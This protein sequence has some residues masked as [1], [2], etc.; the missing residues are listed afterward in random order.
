MKGDLKTKIKVAI[1]LTIAGLA[2]ALL[3]MS[4]WITDLWSDLTPDQ[5]LF[6]VFAPKEGTS[7]EMILDA[8]LHC[9]PW[10]A[11]TVIVLRMLSVRTHK[12]ECPYI[13]YTTALT[14]SFVFAVIGITNM[15]QA[16]DFGHYLSSR[17]EESDFLEQHYIPPETVKLTFPK[18]KRNL[19]YIYLE[20]MEVTFMDKENGG[21]EEKNIIPELTE[22]ALQGE[23]FGGNDPTVNGG[24]AMP[25]TTWTIGG[26]FGQTSGLPL[27]TGINDGN[28]LYAQEHFFPTVTALGDILKDEGYRRV[29]MF[30]SDAEFGGRK[31]CFREHGDYEFRDYNYAIDQGLI[32]PDYKEFWGYEDHKLF[33]F[34]KD[35]LKELSEGEEP[36]AFTMLTVDTHFPEG[37]ECKYC[38]HTFDNQYANAYACSSKQTADFVEWLKKQDFYENTTVILAGDHCTMGGWFVEDVPESYDRKTYVSV[39][40]SAATSA[41]P[42][43]RRTYTTLDMFPTTLSA[44]GVKIEGNRLGLGTDLYSKSPTLAE[45][46]GIEYMEDELYKGTDFVNKLAEIDYE[47]Q[48]WLRADGDYPMVIVHTDSYKDGVAH[49]KAEM[50]GHAYT[51]ALKEFTLHIKTGY[52]KPI[53]DVEMTPLPDG[54]FEADIDCTDLQGQVKIKGDGVGESGKEYTDCIT[55]PPDYPVALERRVYIPLMNEVDKDTYERLLNAVSAECDILYQYFDDEES[56]GYVVIAPETG[57]TLDQKPDSWFEDYKNMQEPEDEEKEEEQD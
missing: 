3:T 29:M 55:S 33:D 19:I 34:A 57:E 22:I 13:F 39:I 52:D 5:I 20:S 41:Y 24:Y 26:M 4:F 7:P 6:Q 51:E 10:I 31:L 36:F 25:G 47:N 30:G 8:C 15:W 35:T 27:M 49:V 17:G 42:S 43:N 23:D 14:F 21:N 32:P 1:V 45:L 2:M 50:A 44:M 12:K 54:S 38:P 46:Y 9:I 16:L 40:N 28:S 37:Y 53:K 48:E 56:P 11:L 18:E